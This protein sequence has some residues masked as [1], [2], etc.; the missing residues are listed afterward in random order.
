MRIRCVFSARQSIARCARCC[1]NLRGLRWVAATEPD[2]TPPSQYGHPSETERP[3][4][5]G[6]RNTTHRPATISSHTEPNG[7][8]N[9]GQRPTHGE[10]RYPWEAPTSQTRHPTPRHQTAGAA[11][12][13]DLDRPHNE[14]RPALITDQAPARTR[15]PQPTAPATKRRR[16]APDEHPPQT[17][18]VSSFSSCVAAYCFNGRGTSP[19][20]RPTTD[21]AAGTE[22]F[23][24]SCA[25]RRPVKTT[26]RNKQ[27]RSPT[28]PP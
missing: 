9:T 11:R 18:D 23:S 1:R 6:R 12:R 28:E 8:T 26:C 27:T 25:S 14:G 4:P 17:M 21:T 10:Q 16:A 7:H 2:R 3:A 13:R 20:E 15:T 22:P 24:S 19:I 5:I